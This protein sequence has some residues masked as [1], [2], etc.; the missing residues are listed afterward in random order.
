M[1]ESVKGRK[2]GWWHLNTHLLQV[3]VEERK[4]EADAWTDCEK[5]ALH[6]SLCLRPRQVLC[7]HIRGFSGHV[8][9]DHWIGH[10]S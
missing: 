6:T 1:K 2:P 4:A 5:A 9:P 8:R 3:Q 7:D 10:L